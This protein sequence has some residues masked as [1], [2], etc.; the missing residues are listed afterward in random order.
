MVL[1]FLYFV[2]ALIDLHAVWASSLEAP[3][4][5]ARASVS[6]DSFIAAE[7]PIALQGILNNIGPDGAKAAGAAPGI[8]V[9]SP[10]KFNPNCTRRVRDGCAVANIS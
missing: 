4:L 8:V 3:W 1:I 2:L 6:I 9:A 5:Q 7:S 10:F